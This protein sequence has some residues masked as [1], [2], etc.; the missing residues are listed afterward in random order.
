MSEFQG[1][2]KN[3][4]FFPYSCSVKNPTQVKRGAG[5]NGER[6]CDIHVALI[7]TPASDIINN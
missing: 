2:E 1:P 4:F 6:H 3:V 5:V 7:V